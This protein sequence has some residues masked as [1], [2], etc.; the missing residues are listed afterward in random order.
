LLF[1]IRGIPATETLRFLT[2]AE[3]VSLTVTAEREFQIT[4]DRFQISRPVLM[5]LF[6]VI[7]LTQ[8]G[9]YLPER[10]Y[11]LGLHQVMS[12]RDGILVVDEI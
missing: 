12:A 11:C 4:P 2:D 8:L 1:L 10:N 6:F 7:L 9:S 3:I 5:C